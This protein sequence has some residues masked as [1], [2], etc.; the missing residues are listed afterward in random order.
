MG[1]NYTHL[2]IEERCRLRGLMEMRLG[3]GEIAPRLGRDPVAIHWE[4]EREH[5]V[6][7]YRANSAQR[8]A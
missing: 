7:G 5:C 2:E 1:T 4:I 6:E 3:I 8:R